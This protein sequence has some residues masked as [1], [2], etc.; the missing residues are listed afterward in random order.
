MVRATQIWA[1]ATSHCT[2][3]TG[4]SHPSA[5]P[6]EMR[7]DGRFAPNG[8]ASQI[9]CEK[10]TQLTATFWRSRKDSNLRLQF[11]NPLVRTCVR[12]VQGWF[13][14][15]GREFL[16]KLSQFPVTP[17]LHPRAGETGGRSHET[18]ASRGAGLQHPG[19]PFLGPREA[20][21]GGALVRRRP[22]T[23]QVIP[24]AFGG[25]QVPFAADECRSAR[26]T[27]R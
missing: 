21:V 16:P 11:R 2:T 6:I 9:G 3:S 14:D 19:P 15:R 25:G 22:A 17:T 10:N 13:A 27:L 4:H 20:S 8:S 12:P 24:H 26:R 23:Q 5:F 7:I 18:L 1:C